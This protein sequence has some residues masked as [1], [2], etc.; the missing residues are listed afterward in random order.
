M[1]ITFGV[2]GDDID[3]RFST[4]GK[5]G[6]A[7]G[8]SNQAEVNATEAGIN[9]STSIDMAGSL[10]FHPLLFVGGRNGP[11]TLARS[12]AMRVKFG[13]VTSSNALFKH[14]GYG[15]QNVEVNAVTAYVNS[16][17]EIVVNTYNNIGQTAAYTTTGASLGT[18]AWHKIVVT[19]TGTTAANGLEVWVDGTRRL[20]TAST[21]PLSPDPM[22]VNGQNGMSFITMGA[23]VIIFSTQT[24]WDEFLVY[25][26][27]IDGSAYNSDVAYQTLAAFDGLDVASGGGSSV[28]GSL[29]RFGF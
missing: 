22:T 18:A 9:G 4:V 12:Y 23:S 21:R 26:E 11:A 15:G 20:Q 25:D 3:A 16:S 28:A 19:F 24:F 27:I 8:N 10:G 1:A 17:G 29:G 7:G 14:G 2:R 5:E 6:F 13:T